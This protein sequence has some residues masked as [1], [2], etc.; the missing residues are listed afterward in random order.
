LTAEAGFT[1]APPG[2]HR[3]CAFADLDG[4]GR[5]DVVISV[6]GQEA[7]IWMNP[8]PTRVIG[9]KLPCAARAAIA[10]ASAHASGWR[11]K[12]WCKPTT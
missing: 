11:A 7:E 10:T 8:A 3:G 12:A 1:A 9:S 6:I 2:L 5:I 4:D